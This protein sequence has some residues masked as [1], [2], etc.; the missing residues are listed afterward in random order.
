[1]KPAVFILFCFCVFFVSAKNIPPMKIRN[2]D[3]FRQLYA[4]IDDPVREIG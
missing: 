4:G 1:M 2:T 3:K